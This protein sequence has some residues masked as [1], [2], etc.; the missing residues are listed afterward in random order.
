MELLS[1]RTLPI[2][3]EIRHV[4]GSAYANRGT[5]PKIGGR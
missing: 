2:F 3:A 1:V 5:L 4:G